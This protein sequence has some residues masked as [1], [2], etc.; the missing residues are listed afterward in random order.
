MYESDL[1]IKELKASVTRL[2][3]RVQELSKG[4]RHAAFQRDDAREVAR[5][6]LPHH[7]RWEELVEEHP[8]L[9]DK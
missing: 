4:E 7:P 3:Q 6:A 2:E 9:E 5:Q 1:E 8:W